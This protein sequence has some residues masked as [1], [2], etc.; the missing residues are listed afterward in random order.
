MAARSISPYRLNAYFQGRSA[1]QSRRR[2]SAVKIPRMDSSSHVIAW[3]HGSDIV[4]V[5][6]RGDVPS[7]IR[8]R[9]V[10]ASS[11]AL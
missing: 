10:L 9:L 6:S 5:A 11:S 8:M 4:G 3:R 1:I 2:Y 7:A